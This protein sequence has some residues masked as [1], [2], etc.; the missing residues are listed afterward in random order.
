[1][2]AMKQFLVLIA[3]AAMLFSCSEKKENSR[4]NRIVIGATDSLHSQI[5][6]ETRKIW[7]Y[8]PD[9][10][11]PGEK[12]PVIYLLDGDWHFHSLTGMVSQLVNNSLIPNTIV[13]GIPNTNRSRD[14]T[15]THSVKMADGSRPDFLKTTGGGENF[16]KFIEQELMPYVESKY[17]VAPYKILIGHSFGGLFAINTLVHHPQL[18]NAYVSIDPSMWWDDRKLLHQTDSLL[19]TNKFPGRILYLSVANTMKPGMD[20]LKVKTDTAS[21]H[22][23][24]RSI[25]A[26]AKL[27][28]ARSSNGLNSKWKYYDADDH[29]SVPFI[30]EYDALRFIFDYYKPA[31]DFR[32]FTPET[33]SAHYKNV[34]E[35]LGYEMLPP[36]GNVDNIG[37]FFLRGKKLDQA[38]VFFEMNLKNY[39]ASA[40]APDSMGDLYIAKGDTV[41]AIEFYRKSLAIQEREHTRKKLDA[42]AK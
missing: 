20:T 30:S 32:D 12:C 42:L 25:L 41:T 31:G 19:K 39:P 6:N 18:F 37:Y 4:D 26:L 11:Q 23:H 28:S 16:T 34:S 40:S 15:P 17:Q 8:I 1:M 24:I 36:E 38:I 14:L 7:V 22:E 13:I 5:L 27:T 9:G 10:L 33:L 35:R 29:G 21:T 3:C 2:A